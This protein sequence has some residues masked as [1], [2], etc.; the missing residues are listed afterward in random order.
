MPGGAGDRTLGSCSDPQA[1][2]AP[3]QR[4]GRIL[5][6]WQGQKSPW[7]R[8]GAPSPVPHLERGAGPP[9]VEPHSMRL[10]LSSSCFTHIAW[11]HLLLFPISVYAFCLRTLCPF[12]LTGALIT[13]SCGDTAV[14]HSV[15]EEPSHKVAQFS[16]EHSPKSRHSMDDP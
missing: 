4:S 2:L 10:G 1:G 14:S 5:G 16:Q 6:I 15:R 12:Q 3:H 9:E 11:P 7:E 13:S 8:P